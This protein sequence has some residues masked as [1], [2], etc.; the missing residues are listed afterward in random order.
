MIGGLVPGTSD[1]IRELKALGI[2][3][4][5]LSNWSRETF[6]RII[7]TCDALALFEDIVL[8]ADYGCIKPEEQIYRIALERFGMP[9]EALLFVD[10]SLPNVRGAE[11]VGLRALTF[12]TAEQL[13]RD[14]A[15]L[16]IPLKPHA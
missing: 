14:L 10:D 13:R 5:A 12:T 3:V 9:V 2:R 11:A 4:F 8:S 6:S 1:I 15:A 16:G 7:H